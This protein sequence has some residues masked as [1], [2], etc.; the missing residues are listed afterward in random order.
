MSVKHNFV[1]RETFLK[2]NRD[3]DISPRPDKDMHGSILLNIPIKE[4]S[5]PS[6]SKDIC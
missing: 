2:A 1:S 5:E 6:M 3:G 4:L